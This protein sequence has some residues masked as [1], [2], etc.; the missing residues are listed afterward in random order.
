[1]KQIDFSEVSLSRNIKATLLSDY[2]HEFIS[3]GCESEKEVRKLG[4]GPHC[5]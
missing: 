2:V 1:M 3:I 4:T 5:L